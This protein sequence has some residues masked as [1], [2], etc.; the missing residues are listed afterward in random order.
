MRGFIVIMAL[1]F[2]IFS[3]EFSDAQ[4]LTAV[5][6]EPVGRVYGQHGTMG[7][8]KTIDVS[9]KMTGGVVSIHWNS[10]NKDAQIITQGTVGTPPFT[11]EGILV[12]ESDLSI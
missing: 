5:C 3:S 12:S 4:E 8:N 1:M 2:S 11:E 6:Q 7:K 10:D 9:D